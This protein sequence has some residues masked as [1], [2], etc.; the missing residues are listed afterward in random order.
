[1][2]SRRSSAVSMSFFVGKT[3]TKSLFKDSITQINNHTKKSNKLYALDKRA[4]MK[5]KIWIPILNAKKE[6]FTF[7][8]PVTSNPTATQ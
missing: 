8:I 3:T 7:L 5:K 6:T 2:L 4:T 1:M